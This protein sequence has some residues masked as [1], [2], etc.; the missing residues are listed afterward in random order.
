MLRRP[1]SLSVKATRRARA[2][3]DFG[4]NARVMGARR[5]SPNHAWHDQVDEQAETPAAKSREKAETSRSFRPD[6]QLP[7]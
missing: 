5:V 6:N 4:A 7:S 2:I 1:K 3:V